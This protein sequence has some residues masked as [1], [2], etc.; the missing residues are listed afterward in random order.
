[1]KK[2]LPLLIVALWSNCLN[3]QGVLEKIEGVSLESPPFELSAQ[4]FNDLLSTNAN[5]LAVIPYGFSPADHPKV[6][7]NSERQWWGERV[8]GASKMVN[9]AKESGYQVM[10]KPQVWIFRGWVGDYGFE[11]DAEWEDWEN[12]YKNFIL[13]FARLSDSLQ[14]DLFCLGT[15]Y[16]RAT[17]QRPQFWFDLIDSVRKVY[18]GKITY[19]ANWDEYENIPFWDKLDYIGVDAYFPLSL[20]DTPEISE[21]LLNWLPLKARMKTLSDSLEMPILLTE[22]GYRSVDGAAGKQWDLNSKPFNEEAQRRAYLAL[23]ESL[24]TE[25][26][27]A[28]GFFWKWRFRMENHKEEDRSY[29]PQNKPAMKIIQ[30]VYNR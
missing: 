3:G 16:K 15:E 29:S 5:W 10:M 18:K 28:G 20:N 7:F 1:V 4:D 14:V 25:S 13:T 21:L 12:S 23:F 26:W 24:W 9:L 2:L 11:T 8:E 19:A 17:G 22:F 30:S 27:I 6:T